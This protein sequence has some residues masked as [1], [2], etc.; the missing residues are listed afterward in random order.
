M[1]I[2]SLAGVLKI[3]GGADPSPEERASLAKEA[4]LMVLARATA[5][6][7]NIKNVEIDTVRSILRDHTGEDFDPA[8]IRVAANSR[9]FE[10]APLQKY[11]TSVGRKLDVLDRIEISQ[12]L[13]EVI[14]SDEHISSREIGFFNEI[15]EALSLSPAELVGLV[16]GGD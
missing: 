9:L 14:R 3:F 8:D 11:V 15:A 1:S 7:S 13:A 5:A 10:K 2:S 4:M 6:D 16:E 12:A